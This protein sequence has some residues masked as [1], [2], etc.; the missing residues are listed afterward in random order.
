M[1]DSKA[2]CLMCSQSELIKRDSSST[3]ELVEYC[4]GFVKWHFACILPAD[5]EAVNMHMT[6]DFFFFFKDTNKGR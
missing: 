2:C 3:L 6:G 1:R 5:C 4:N